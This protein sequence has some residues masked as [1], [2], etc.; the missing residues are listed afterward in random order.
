MT[1]E[2]MPADKGAEDRAADRTAI[3]ALAVYA[4]ALCV[5]VAYDVLVPWEWV[6]VRWMAAADLFAFLLCLASWAGVARY[7]PGRVPSKRLPAVGQ[8][9][10]LD[11][12]LAEALTIGRFCQEAPFG[13]TDAWCDIC[14]SWKPP[15]AHHCSQC[16][17]CSM[18]MDHHCNCVAHCVGFRNI[19]CHIVWL[20]YCCLLHAFVAVSMLFRI[21][22]AT[23]AIFEDA[24]A[25]PRLLAVSCLLTRVFLKA[26][27]AFNSYLNQVATGWPS[28]V[29]LKK[30]KAAMS[31]AEEIDARADSNAEPSVHVLQLRRAVARL[32]LRPGRYLGPFAPVSGVLEGL[33]QVFGERPSWRW[34]LPLR[35]GGTGD[36][37]QPKFYNAEVCA[38]W[39]ELA[40]CLSRFSP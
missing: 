28:Y 36:P 6:I 1:P 23:L 17:R 9:S 20:G 13:P 31:L 33:E 8:T 40:T 39:A 32:T 37:L 34:A 10:L 11:P 14:R 35:P 3:I 5:Y 18:W 19:R 7:G 16:N 29:L 27:K 12:R 25:L 4:V 38:A 26:W 24:W 21:C 15:L 2:L 22:G 30:F